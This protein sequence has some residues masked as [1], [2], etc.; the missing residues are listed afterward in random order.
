MFRRPLTELRI[1]WREFLYWQA[2]LT[3]EH[4]DLAENRRTASLMATIT[5]MSG[6]VMKD[7]QQVTAEDFLGGPKPQTMEQQIAFMRSLG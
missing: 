6:K 5:N 4:P 1:T 2:F 7:N 3:E